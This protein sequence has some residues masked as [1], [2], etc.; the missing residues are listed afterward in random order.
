MY[1]TLL[2]DPRCK[3]IWYYQS[4]NDSTGKF[5]FMDNSNAPLPLMGTIAAEAG[6]A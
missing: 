5:G 6:M 1:K 2:A 3:G 4:H